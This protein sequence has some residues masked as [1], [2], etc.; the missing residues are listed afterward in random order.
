MQEATISRSYVSLRKHDAKGA[1]KHLRFAGMLAQHRHKDA[2]ELVTHLRD[3]Y[4][5]VSGL[6]PSTVSKYQI[7]YRNFV[8]AAG[9]TPDVVA[10]RLYEMGRDENGIHTLC[11]AFYAADKDVQRAWYML[12]KGLD[13]R[14][15]KKN[16]KG[17]SD[18]GL[19]AIMTAVH[20]ARKRGVADADIVAA[21]EAL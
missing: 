3:T 10:Q 9:E 1:E 8:E 7:V 21:I 16:S 18:D 13:V 19:S 2:V 5:A 11:R 20:A 14:G 12:K 4:G 6:S 17:T 15:D